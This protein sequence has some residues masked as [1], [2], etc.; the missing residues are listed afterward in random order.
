MHRYT[1]DMPLNQRAARHAK[2][3]ASL[4]FCCHS[5]HEARV[6]QRT[7][8]GLPPRHADKLASDQAREAERQPKERAVSAA[9]Q[10]H[11][12]GLEWA[13]SGQADPDR[14]QAEAENAMRHLADQGFI[15]DEVVQIF[16]DAAPR[17]VERA[18][19]ERDEVLPTMPCLSQPLCKA[20]IGRA[21]MN[22]GCVESDP[23]VALVDITP[24]AVDA[25]FYF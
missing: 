20:A 23:N 7:A 5:R 12:L 14:L 16:R 19:H 10:A 21:F 24:A 22:A 6:A 2:D 18:R 9:L 3:V 1:K 4:L 25:W 11:D 17:Y 8:L 13:Q 15:S